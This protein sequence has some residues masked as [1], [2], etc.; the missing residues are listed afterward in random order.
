MKHVLAIILCAISLS[1]FAQQPMSPAPVQGRPSPEQMRKIMEMSMG[2]MVPVMVKM[3][4]GMI[5][6]ML[7]RA[8]DPATA[9]RLAK[10]KKNLYDA[11][12]KDGFTSQQ[13]LEIVVS[14]ALPSAA[15]PMK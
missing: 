14:T 7:E 10:F 3:T 2:A 6:A 15:P 5:E 8:A 9:T 1:A 11:L 4:D 13:A 12:V